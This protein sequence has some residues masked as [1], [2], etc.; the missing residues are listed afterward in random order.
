MSSPLLAQARSSGP[1]SQTGCGPA[2]L[3][4]SL[5][6]RENRAKGLRLAKTPK[7]HEQLEK[8]GLEELL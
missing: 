4:G 1:P 8:S 5:N 6:G 2:G 7:I 3:R